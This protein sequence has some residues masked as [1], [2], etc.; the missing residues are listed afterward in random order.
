MTSPLSVA[1]DALVAEADSHDAN[2]IRSMA[3][4]MRHTYGKLHVA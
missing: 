2:A 1:A 4:E 3:N